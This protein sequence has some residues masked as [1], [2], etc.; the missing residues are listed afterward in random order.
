MWWVQRPLTGQDSCPIKGSW[1]SYDNF[2]T[3]APAVHPDCR[4]LVPLSAGVRL[5]A[6]VILGRWLRVVP[7]APK[8]R[9]K[10]FDRGT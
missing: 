5:P 4:A 8:H 3:I 6:D 1:G 7:R 10:S 2:A 9:A